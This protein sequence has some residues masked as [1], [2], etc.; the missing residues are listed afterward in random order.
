MSKNY[1]D[2]NNGGVEFFKNFLSSGD[3]VSEDFLEVILA[4][5]IDQENIKKRRKEAENFPIEMKFNRW[6]TLLNDPNTYIVGSKQYKDF[7][8]NFRIPIQLFDHLVDIC[9]K[10]NIFEEKKQ[11]MKIHMK[12]KLL[13]CLKIL[14]RD[15]CLHEVGFNNFISKESVRRWFHLF[16]KNFS[17]LK[18]E[19]IRILD[20]D[21]LSNIMDIYSEC[22]FPGAIGSAD[23][24]HLYWSKCPDAYRV[25]CTGK[26][27][28]PT[29]SYLAVV[30]HNRY[31]WY[32]SEGFFGS[33]NDSYIFKFDELFII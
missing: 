16:L 19:F 21:H 5:C 2:F 17:K 4:G 31:C 11:D 28:K 14:G 12:Y 25:L 18:D 3:A 20:K 33:S 26:E 30:S 23:C 27:N 24:T 13:C 32:L 8:L 1:Y 6:N 29:L 7:R 22:G 10:Y 9:R 15:L